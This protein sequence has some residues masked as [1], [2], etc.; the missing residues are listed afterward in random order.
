MVCDRLIFPE[1][2]GESHR[3]R[4]HGRNIKGKKRNEEFELTE[5]EYR[6]CIYDVEDGMTGCWMIPIAEKERGN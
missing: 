1:K 3:C 5:E 6:K 2:E 4:G